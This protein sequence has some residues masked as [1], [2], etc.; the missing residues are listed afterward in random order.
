MGCFRERRPLQTTSTDAWVELLKV[1]T[2]DI[3]GIWTMIS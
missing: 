1:T 2:G 3:G